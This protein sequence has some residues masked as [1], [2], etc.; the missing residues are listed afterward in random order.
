MCH[1][2]ITEMSLLSIGM[3]LKDADCLADGMGF[4]FSNFPR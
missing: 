1:M 3:F 4:I 2:L